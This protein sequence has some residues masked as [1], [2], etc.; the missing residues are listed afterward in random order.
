MVSR[1]DA[2]DF[3]LRGVTEPYGFDR[4]FISALPLPPVLKTAGKAIRGYL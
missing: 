2:V 4:M 1:Q 3:G